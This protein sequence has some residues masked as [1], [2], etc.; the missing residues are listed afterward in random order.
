MNPITTT[1]QELSANQLLELTQ[2]SRKKLNL[3]H[4]ADLSIPT[5]TIDKIKHYQSLSDQLASWI[6]RNART[7]IITAL[8]KGHGWTNI[9]QYLPTNH[10]V[11]LAS[12]MPIHSFA[13]S[14]AVDEIYLKFFAGLDADGIPIR[15]TKS[16]DGVP[17]I[18]L[19][20]GPK[21]GT[22]RKLDI[23]RSQGL[24]PVIDQL[25]QQ[26]KTIFPGVKIVHRWVG[27][28]GFILEAVWDHQSYNSRIHGQQEDARFKAR[29]PVQVY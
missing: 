13:P 1:P 20:Q 17:I 9:Y 27:K 4:E 26:F 19:I 8:S 25:S 21:I 10:P 7:R 2:K 5:V 14:N 3:H 12:S 23:L 29:T 15:S 18:L 22:S 28:N 24:N 11:G 6:I 16:N